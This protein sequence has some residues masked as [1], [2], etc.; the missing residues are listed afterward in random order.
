MTGSAFVAGADGSGPKQFGV[1]G[2][3][4]HKTYLW[5]KR[6]G[7]SAFGPVAAVQHQPGGPHGNRPTLGSGHELLTNA[8]VLRLPADNQCQYPHKTIIVF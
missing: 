8:P 6:M 5:I 7:G 1:S 3:G 2:G 4:M